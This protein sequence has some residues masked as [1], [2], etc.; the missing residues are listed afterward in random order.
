M[1]FGPF[2]IGWL[3]R[4]DLVFDIGTIG[5][6]YLMFL[7]GLGFN[8]STFNENKTSA[9]G[10]GIL[11]F[12]FPF[13]LSLMAGLSSFEMGI[14]AAALLGSMWAS[15]TLVA[16]PDVRAAGLEETRAVRDAVSGGVVADV[17]SPL[18][19]AIAKSY[20][21]IETVD[22]DAPGT[23]SVPTL[24]PLPEHPESIPDGAVALM[25]EMDA[26]L[27]LLDWAGPRFKPRWTPSVHSPRCQRWPLI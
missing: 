5:I 7:A 24:P 9:L 17:L 12:V 8:V 13:V 3:G 23:Q 22:P 11:S 19:L 21:V 4:T 15:N 27:V 6:L 14:L 10:Y 18:V 25:E 20:V 1:L 26:T 16:Y 2:G